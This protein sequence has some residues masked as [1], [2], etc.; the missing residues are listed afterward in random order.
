MYDDDDDDDC[1]K[2]KRKKCRVR[3]AKDEN[4]VNVV[5]DLFILFYLILYNFAS[6][7]F[8][9]I[10]FRLFRFVSLC[11]FL[12]FDVLYQS[13]WS[14]MWTH[15]HVYFWQQSAMMVIAQCITRA[16]RRKHIFSLFFGQLIE[17]EKWRDGGRGGRVNWERRKWTM[18]CHTLIRTETKCD[19]LCV[20]RCLCVQ[21]TSIES[22][23]DY[24][25]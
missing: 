19:V 7:E 6:V 24:F 5:Y 25:V 3:R 10:F 13:S 16:K 2:T 1:N 20:C 21:Q 18:K 9:P 11:C 14:H 4:N 12:S 23:N 8:E 15:T 22:T 17:T